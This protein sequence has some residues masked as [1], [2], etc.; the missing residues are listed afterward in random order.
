ML[1][2]APELAAQ[3]TVVF[4][5]ENNALGE[6]QDLGCQVRVWPEIALVHPRFGAGNVGRLLHDHTVGLARLIRRIRAHRPSVLVSNS[7]NVWAGGLTARAQGVPHVQVVHSL[8]FK[9][10]WQRHVALLRVYFRCLSAFASCFVGV[11]DA[12]RQMLTEYGIK[13]EKISVVPNGFDA[14]DLRRTDRAP[15]PAMVRHLLQGRHPV[16]VSVGRIA[17]MK[18]QD[19]LV[20]ALGKI[21]HLYPSLVCLMAGRLGA[22]NGAEDTRA[23]HHRLVSDIR[24]LGLQGCVHLLGEIDYVPDL[25]DR[26]DVYVHPSLTES[27]SRVVAEALIC[28]KPVVSS[29]TGGIPET[30]GPH[31]ALLVPPGDAEALAAALVRALNEKGLRD[32]MVACGRAYVLDRYEVTSTARTF[33]RVLT[34]V[35]DG[36]RGSLGE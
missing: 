36:A 28:G 30:V 15:A 11:S 10:R 22:E 20:A 5:E 23:F 7:E 26:A 4:H 12:V 33:Y 35:T 2:H 19:V 1:R 3:S 27:F 13:A 31:G 17:P 34:A 14:F 32:E 25:L 6:Y 8:A 18:G 16:V 21:R 9:Y 29:R 24:R